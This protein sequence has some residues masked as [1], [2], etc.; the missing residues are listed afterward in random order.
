MP[1]MNAQVQ[2]FYNAVRPRF[3]GEWSL[4]LQLQL[5]FPRR[6]GES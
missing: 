3:V 5:M 6:G 2:G 4:R 1:P